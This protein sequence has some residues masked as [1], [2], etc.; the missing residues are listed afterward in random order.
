MPKMSIVTDKAGKILGS[1]R[2]GKSKD[3]KLECGIVPLKGQKVQEVD[4]PSGIEKVE[5]AAEIHKKLGNL[6]K[7]N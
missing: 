7:K 4:A 1:A 2:T 3:G 6:I 5:S